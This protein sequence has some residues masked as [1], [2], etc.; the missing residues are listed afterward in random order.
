MFLLQPLEIIF[1]FIYHKE[2]SLTHTDASENKSTANSIAIG[3]GLKAP[4][5]VTGTRTWSTIKVG[6]KFAKGDK[7]I[8]E[9]AIEV[10]AVYTGTLWVDKVNI[11]EGTIKETFLTSMETDQS[12]LVFEVPNYKIKHGLTR[13]PE[14]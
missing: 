8:Q 5:T 1:N 3:V 14:K 9:Y 7:M 12:S 11:S 13:L 4:V 6:A 10:K 2:I